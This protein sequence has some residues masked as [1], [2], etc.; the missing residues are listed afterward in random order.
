MKFRVGDKVKVV[1]GPFEGSVGIIDMV[2]EEDLKIPYHVICSSES[3]QIWVK[4][5]NLELITDDIEEKKKSS[6]KTFNYG[7]VNITT[8]SELKYGDCFQMLEG[9]YKGQYG[10]V[11]SFPEKCDLGNNYTPIALFFESE[12]FPIVKYVILAAQAEKVKK[13]TCEITFKED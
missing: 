6:M 9:D 1:G 4:E 8:L 11:C 5:E 13:V 7:S 3:Y 12:N 10:M 2:D